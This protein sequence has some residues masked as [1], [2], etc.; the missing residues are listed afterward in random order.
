MAG[1][2]AKQEVLQRVIAVSKKTRGNPSPEMQS[3]DATQ[4]LPNIRCDLNQE[5]L[6][7]ERELIRQALAK[8]GGR[9]TQ[10]AS[11]LG[12]TYQGLAYTIEKRHKDLR[13]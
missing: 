4:P 7:T 2:I 5:K 11:L 3:E 13:C 12:M 6:K 10:A 8:V 9:L 1:N